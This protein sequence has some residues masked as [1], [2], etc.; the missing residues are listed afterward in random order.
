MSEPPTDE[1]KAAVTVVGSPG[2]DPEL[3]ATSG[4]GTGG[5]VV[6][7]PGSGTLGPLAGP[8]GGAP[9]DVVGGAF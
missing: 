8:E 7:G 4:D 5:V 6:P 9:A 3:G 2:V 1:L